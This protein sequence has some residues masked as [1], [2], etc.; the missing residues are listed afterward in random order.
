MEVSSLR[1]LQLACEQGRGSG[2][3][4]MPE[5]AARNASTAALRLRLAADADGALEIRILKRRGGSVMHPVR[6]D[7]ATLRSAA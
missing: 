7:R 3:L 2:F 5:E 6:L 1:R 4:F